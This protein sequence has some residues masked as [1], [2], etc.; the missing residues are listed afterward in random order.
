[1]YGGTPRASASR[2]DEHLKHID[3]WLRVTRYA[4]QLT[5][6]SGPLNLSLSLSLSLFLSRGE[7]LNGG[8]I[9]LS[10]NARKFCLKCLV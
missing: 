8:M 7:R 5:R 2:L 10:L 9:G 3:G 6:G 4:E 1:M